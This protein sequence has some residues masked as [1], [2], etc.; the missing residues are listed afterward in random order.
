MRQIVVQKHRK[1]RKSELENLIEDRHYPNL[2]SA[3]SSLGMISII[4][5]F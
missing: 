3:F 2:L 1:K 5:F 4:N